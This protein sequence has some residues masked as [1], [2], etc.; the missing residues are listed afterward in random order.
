[1]LNLTGSYIQ[2]AHLSWLSYLSLLFVTVFGSN[3]DNVGGGKGGAGSQCVTSAPFVGNVSRT[4]I[5]H[6]RDRM[7]QEIIICIL[8]YSSTLTEQLQLLCSPYKFDYVWNTLC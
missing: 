4:L 7:V 1:M 8:Y 3:D 2:I 5:L 6:F